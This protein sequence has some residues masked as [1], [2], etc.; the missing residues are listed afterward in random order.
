LPEVTATIINTNCDS[1][2]SR[3]SAGL[4]VLNSSPGFGFNMTGDDVPVDFINSN[5][6]R[7]F[8]DASLGQDPVPIMAKT[9]VTWNYPNNSWPWESHA[10]ITYKVNIVGTQSS[11][12][13][14]NIIK[15]TAIPAF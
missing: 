4:W 10:V 14:N 11:G 7:P 13:Y 3:T 15:F 5:Y 1:G 6:F 8:A 12:T 9:Q 2:C